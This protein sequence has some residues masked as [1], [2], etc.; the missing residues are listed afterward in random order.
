MESLPELANGPL[1]LRQFTDRDLPDIVRLAGDRL[2]ADTTL[3]IP[4]PYSEKDG[5]AWLKYQTEELKT[6]KGVTYAVTLGETGELVGSISLSISKA[7]NNAEL[8]YWIGR[9]YWNKG[10]ATEA[11][12]R[13]IQFGFEELKFNRIHAHYMVRNPAS[14]RVMVKAGMKPEGL[15]RQAVLKDGNYEDIVVY[16][17]LRGEFEEN[18]TM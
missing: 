8:G 15:L 6:G 12:R 16:S 9:P 10:Y 7:N 18:R 13:L 5:E 1:I 17:I 11:A 3:R 14:G 2:I 4:H